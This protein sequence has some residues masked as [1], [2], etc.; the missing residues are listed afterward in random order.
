MYNNPIFWEQGLFLQ[1][2]HFQL[3]QQ[4]RRHVLSEMLGLLHP[5][6]WGVRRFAVNEAALLNGAF[7]LSELEMLLP[8]GDLIILN[9]NAVLA[10]RPFA[11]AWTSPE[12]PLNVSVGLAPLRFG[13]N[14][15]AQTD[16]TAPDSFRFVTPL[17]PDQMP[18]ML[19]DGPR[20]DVRTLRYNL[21][22][23]FGN[24]GRD[25]QRLPVA[26]LV[27]DGERV[28]LESR[29]VPPCLDINAA[30][31]L[32]TLLRDVRDTLVSRSK[33][34]EEYKI[35]AGDAKDS[36]ISTLSGIT[37]FSLLGVLSRNAPVLEQMLAAPVF[38]PWNAYVALCQLVGELSVFS[39]SLSPLGETPQGTRALPAYDHLDLYGCFSAAANIISRLVDTLVVG[40]AF[41][42]VL[43]PRNGCL[44]TI[45][46]QPAL[47]NTYSYWLLLRTA[48]T[49]ELEAQVRRL[50]KFAPT[51]AMPGIVA[52]AL[53][54][55]RLIAADQPPAGLPR[56]QDT[57]YFMIDQAD[58]LWT[59]VL[60]QGD[61]SFT[62]PQAPDDLLAQL[63]V[64]QR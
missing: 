63:T 26:R 14:N 28:Q 9:D 56:R 32:H 33:Q 12:V 58:P 22:L 31:A 61:V 42:F 35:V 2:Q 11:E 37:L 45:M 38:H 27:R 57:L 44:G 6:F 48:H 55:I 23:C 16:A 19:S 53:P 18:D 20:V 47:S 5:W 10:P 25:L 52:R 54:G 30:P 59:Q 41:T 62:L 8:S 51:T 7:E 50:A 60:Q 46:P 13:G 21:Q 15:V 49:Q 29:F 43:E 40:P 39:S 36:G 4:Q 3:E 24:E 1:P 64:I 34:L 17:S